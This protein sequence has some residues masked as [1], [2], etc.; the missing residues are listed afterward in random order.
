MKKIIIIALV[1]LCAIACTFS[2]SACKTPSNGSQ[3][4][5]VVENKID[6]V[7]G[8]TRQISVSSLEKGET[9]SYASND[10][11]IISVTSDGV[12]EGLKIGSAVIKVTSSLGRSALIP[13]TVYDPAFYPVPYI[14]ISKLSPKHLA[15]ILSE[16]EI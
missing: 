12:I 1:A 14:S 10:E 13:V 4:L 3:S 16:T 7:L 5:E 11:S 15:S 9:L 8:Q 2:M 6:M